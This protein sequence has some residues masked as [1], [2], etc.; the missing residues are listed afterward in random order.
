MDNLIEPDVLDELHWY[1]MQT[2]GTWYA[3]Q[4]C[5]RSCATRR[6]HAWTFQENQGLVDVSLLGKIK[7]VETPKWI[8]AL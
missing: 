7:T 3:V 6:L 5:C 8:V 1:R 4:A 2:W